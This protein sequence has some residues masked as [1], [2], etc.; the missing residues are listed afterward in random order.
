MLL[1]PVDKW[2]IIWIGYER[3]RKIF[4]G[5][6]SFDFDLLETFSSNSSIET[7]TSN[8]NGKRRFMRN[9]I[10]NNLVESI[11]R[12]TKIIFIN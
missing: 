3:I 5:N 9:R 4:Q 2:L 8:K 7:K 1:K 11:K 10:V 12:E 6:I